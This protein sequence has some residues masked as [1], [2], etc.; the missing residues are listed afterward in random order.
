MSISIYEASVPVFKRALSN[1][2]AIL[3]K[4]AA[5][6]ESA[7]FDVAVLLSARLYPDM[8]PFP[9][10][11]YIASD[12]A[13]AVAARLAG[14][15]PPKFENGEV[16]VSALKARL[17]QAIAYLDTISADQLAGAEDRTIIV[18]KRDQTV[19]WV[20]RDYLFNYGVPNFFFHVTTAYAILRHNGVPI[21]KRDFLGS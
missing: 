17:E 18:T 15:E 11:I 1:L 2:S 4:A 7:K 9:R 13:T 14:V 19:T 10:Q 3:D 6:A 21:G 16:T 20:G 8:H 12:T 5:H